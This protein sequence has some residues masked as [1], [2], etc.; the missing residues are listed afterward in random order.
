MSEID[1]LLDRY[2]KT[3]P[4][5]KPSTLEGEEKEIEPTK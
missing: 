2:L 3:H 1:L 4:K 5:K